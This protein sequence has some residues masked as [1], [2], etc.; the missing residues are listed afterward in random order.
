MPKID[1]LR[2]RLEELNGD[3]QA[4]TAK[5]EAEKRDL[6][7]DERAELDK[8]L[9]EFQT[10]QEDINRLEVLSQQ[11]TALTAGQGRKTLAAAPV[12]APAD[13]DLD[14]PAPRR[15]LSQ[16]RVPAEVSTRGRGGFRSLGDFAYHVARSCR[17]GHATDPRLLATASTYGTEGVGADGGFAVPPDFRAS[18]MEKVMGE[19]SL[20]PFCDQITTSS[21]V[22]TMPV[23]ETTPWQTSGGI[24]AYWDGEAAAATQSK[25]SLEERTVKLN[26]IRALVPVTEELLEDAPG[27]DSYLRKKAP[28]KI[29]FKVS[30]SILNSGTGVGQPLSVLN[31]P[32][33]VTVSKESSQ[34]ADTIVANNIIKM[35]SRLYGPCR[36]NARWFINQDIEPYL[37]S[38]SMPGRNNVGDSQS[39]WGFPV[40]TPAGGLSVGPYA[41]LMGRPVIATQAC[42]TLGDLGDIILADMS[43]YLA[44]IKSGTNPRVETSMHLWFD[45]DLMA[46]KFVLRIGGIPWW[47][48]TI[49]ARDGS[50]TLSCFVALEARA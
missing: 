42:E 11:T 41:T 30:L 21:N 17:E 13:D 9:A 2:E 23:D 39:S 18:V 22:F 29:A 48:S 32:A 14:E 40:Y 47:G 25:P 24:L 26:K 3:A 1:E 27:M 12:A 15:T 35:W 50:N 19:A 6:S 45:Q 34:T 5:A 20:L 49:A 37:N 36:S 8:I 4:L 44:L 16:H 28:E 7:A 33:L 46:F 43:Q 31:S 10:T 38:M